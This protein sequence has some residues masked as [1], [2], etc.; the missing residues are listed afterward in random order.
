MRSIWIAVLLI[1]GLAA[2]TYAETHVAV[3]ASANWMKPR[4]SALGGTR[5]VVTPTLGLSPRKGFGLTYGLNWFEQRIALENIGGPAADGKLHIR[6]VMLGV[7][8]TF[9]GGGT[10]LSV[11]A[12]GGYAFNTLDLLDETRRGPGEISISNSTVVRPGVRLWRSLHEH[13]GLSFFGGYVYTR[14]KLTVDGAERT[15]K[16]D[17]T[18]LSAGAAF[19]F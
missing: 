2:S 14:P 7:S 1:A 17:Y 13:F 8:Y 5:T 19:V 4:E 12:V 16:A 9:G 15:L 6:P 10:L 18:V 11:S 3:G